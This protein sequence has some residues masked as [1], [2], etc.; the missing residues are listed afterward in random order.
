MIDHNEGADKP[1]DSSERP[2]VPTDGDIQIA[3]NKTVEEGKKRADSAR[4]IIGGDQMKSLKEKGYFW[5]EGSGK[6]T[7]RNKNIE[8]TTS[9]GK[10]FQDPKLLVDG[11]LALR[12]GNEY[13]YARKMKDGTYAPTARKAYVYKNTIISKDFSDSGT[14]VTRDIEKTQTNFQKYYNRIKLDLEERAKNTAD[15]S[16]ARELISKQHEAASRIAN[17]SNFSDAEKYEE[18]KMILQSKK[19]LTITHHIDTLGPTSSQVE[20]QQ[21]MDE[22]QANV[23]DL[24]KYNEWITSGQITK[25]P[26]SLKS[27]D[28]TVQG[29]IRHLEMVQEKFRGHG[30]IQKKIAEYIAFGNKIRFDLGK[31]A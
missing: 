13:Y 25:D 4:F 2:D 12:K 6:V 19:P 24:N 10:I 18:I 23:N 29:H 15:G 3:A 9:L 30:D 8:M 20:Y 21:A 26:Q 7:F 31:G 11:K 14:I 1:K 28:S 5:D 27:I 22:T 17:D 16:A